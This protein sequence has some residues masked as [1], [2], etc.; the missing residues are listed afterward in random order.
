[1][2]AEEKV[3]V[4]SRIMT[5]MAMIGS[6]VPGYGKQLVSEVM[7][8]LINVNNDAVIF[9]PTEEGYRFNKEAK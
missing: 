6:V 3:A 1:M 9:E 7:L 8:D 2:T 4:W 5:K